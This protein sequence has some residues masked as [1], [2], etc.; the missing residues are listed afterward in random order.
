[1]FSVRHELDYKYYLYEL[2]SLF[3]SPF[4][5]NTGHVIQ[6]VNKSKAFTLGKFSNSVFFCLPECSIDARLYREGPTKGR[7]DTGFLGFPPFPSK[8]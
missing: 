2:S 8:R 4:S 5:N 3:N 1:V 6:I 7:L